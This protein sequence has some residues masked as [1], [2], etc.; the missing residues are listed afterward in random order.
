MSLYRF[1]RMSAL[2]AF[3]GK[4]RMKIFNMGAAAAFAFVT[5]WLYGDIAGYLQ[6]NF[7]QWLG[8]ALVSKT[9]IVYAALFFLLWQ[10]RPSERTGGS[11]ATKSAPML[12]SETDTPSRLEELAAKPKLTSRKE[13]ILKK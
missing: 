7:P 11:P 6:T 4:Y 1:A 13:A 2:L 10:L 9:L 12:L 8:L 5:S 3:A